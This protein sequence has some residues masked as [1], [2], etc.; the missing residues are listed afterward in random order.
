[1]QPKLT[2][3]NVIRVFHGDNSNIFDGLITVVSNKYNT[4]GH[5]MFLLLIYTPEL[6]F[7]HAGC[8]GWGGVN[9]LNLIYKQLESDGYSFIKMWKNL[10][11]YLSDKKK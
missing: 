7:A 1:M 3:G 8:T 4:D 2:Y 5:G 6:E 9:D 10:D 11:N